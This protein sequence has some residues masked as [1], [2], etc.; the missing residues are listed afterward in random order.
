M[1]KIF[2]VNGACRPGQHYMVNLEPKL[3]EIKAMVDA[4]EYFVINR[5]RQYG[6]TT[7]L[8]ALADYLKKD[9]DVV[10][11]VSGNYRRLPQFAVSDFQPSRH[12]K[13]TRKAV[14]L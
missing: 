1:A 4:G 3:R 10:N 2:N 14:F 6:K 5:A 11:F 9:Y 13:H 7:T 8:Y 12:G